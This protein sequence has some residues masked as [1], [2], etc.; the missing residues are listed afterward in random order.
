MCPAAS[1][2]AIGGLGDF[3]FGSNRL[4]GK[5]GLGSLSY[6]KHVDMAKRYNGEE[7]YGFGQQVLASVVPCITLH[8][9]VSSL[10]T[11]LHRS[12]SKKLRVPVMIGVQIILLFP[13]H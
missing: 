2:H 12:V 5:T 8:I 4:V 13:Y 11:V 9:Y 1:S 10:Y 6:R 7:V 3:G